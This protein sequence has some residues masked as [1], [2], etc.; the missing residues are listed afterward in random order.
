M[1]EEK[2]SQTEDALGWV[3][4]TD[5]LGRITIPKQVRRELGIEPGDYLVFTYEKADGIPSIVVRKQE[6]TTNGK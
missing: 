5:S 3:R 4:K 2:A 1:A 6:L